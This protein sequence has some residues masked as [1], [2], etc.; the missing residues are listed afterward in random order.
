MTDGSDAGPSQARLRVVEDRLELLNLEGAY[1]PA[2][3][4]RQGEVW[5]ALF[6]DDGVYEGRQ[7]AGLG[8]QNFIR[9]RESLARFC[10]T[11]SSSGMHAMQAPHLELD[12]DR[13]TGRV[14]FRF[15]SMRVDEH[16]RTHGREVVGYYDVAYLRTAHGWRM[17]R[18]ITNYLEIVQ[19]LTLPYGPAAADVWE[20]PP[21]GDD[22]QDR[23]T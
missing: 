10:N 5:A 11:Q 3:D 22:Y 14:H 20:P 12:G 4:S 16:G 15:Q 17:Q 6:T 8:P 21:P 23:R 13:A 19:R 9:G 7:L 1:G 18:R 2:Y